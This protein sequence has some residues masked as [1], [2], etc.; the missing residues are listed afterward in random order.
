LFVEVSQ[1]SLST[2][3]QHVVKAVSAK[4]PIPILSG[5]CLRANS[6]GLTLIACNSA[7][8]LQ[9]RIPSDRDNLLIQKSGSIVAPARYFIDIIRNLPAGLVTL[10]M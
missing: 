9:Y 2:A 5:I 6:S 10:E 7:M 4:S 1:K 8:M 3:L